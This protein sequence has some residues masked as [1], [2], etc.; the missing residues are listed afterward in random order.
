MIL[1][2]QCIT[3]GFDMTNVCKVTSFLTDNV[4]VAIYK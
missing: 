4:G 2:I 3:E 1:E